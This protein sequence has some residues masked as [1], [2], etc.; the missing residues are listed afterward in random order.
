MAFGVARVLEEG[1]FCR[2]SGFPGEQGLFENEFHQ[3]S[4]FLS[5][6]SLPRL[7]SQGLGPSQARRERERPL[8]LDEELNLLLEPVGH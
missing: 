3:R 4:R 5:Q 1:S 6:D 2:C 8:P 7:F